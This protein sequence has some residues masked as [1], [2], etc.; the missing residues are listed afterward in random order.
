LKRAS[1]FGAKENPPQCRRI[2]FAC[3][4]IQK[5]T[6]RLKDSIKQAVFEQLAECRSAILC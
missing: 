2:F 4:T 3:A 6:E 5:R 1:N